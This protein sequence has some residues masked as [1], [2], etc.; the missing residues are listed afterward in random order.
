MSDKF[1]G[2]AIPAGSKNGVYRSGIGN[3]VHDEWNT[4][5]AV[6]ADDDGF[7]VFECVTTGGIT[8]NPSEDLPCARQI[9]VVS[10]VSGQDGSD[11]KLKLYGTNVL[12]QNITEEL[13]LDGTTAVL[14]TKAFKTIDTV[15]LPKRYTTPVLQSYKLPISSG[16]GT[17]S[18]TITATV[19]SAHVTG[20]PL[21]VTLEV[22]EDDTATVVA[23]KI[24]SALNSNTSVSAVFDAT[25]DGANVIITNKIYRA[26]DST[27]LLAVTDTDTTGVAGGTGVDTAGVNSDK[28]TIGWT[29]KLGL[30]FCAKG[31]INLGTYFND[32]VES[33]A[34]TFTCDADEVEKNMI[35]LNSALNGSVV[36]TT[37]VVR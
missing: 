34:P 16:A 33:T 5:E 15:D 22:V 31:C 17:A 27:Q 9:K 2:I 8:V 30:R 20:S 26:D 35:D 1:I 23:G 21:A 29:D 36:D 32:V 24:A 11:Y 13:T 25:T 28:I 6:A 12:N 7:G 18:G 10:S 4:T 3:V 14:S 37:Y 19:T